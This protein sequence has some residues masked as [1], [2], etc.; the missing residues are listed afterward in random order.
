MNQGGDAL[1]PSEPA[2]QKYVQSM[3]DRI[4]PGYELV[5]RVMTFGLDARWRSRL[6][7]AVTGAG[8]DRALDIGCG[9]GD[10]VREL[11]RR[12]VGV[13]GLDLSMGML[14]IAGGAEPRVQAVGEAL[15]F[16]DS[17]FDAVT[18]GFAV[19]NFSD[20]RRVFAEVARVLKP[21]GRFGVLEVATPRNPLIRVGHQIYFSKVV[22][23][24]G[25]LLSKDHAAYRYL[26]MSVVYLPSPQE[27]GRLLVDCGFFPPTRIR[28]GM[29]AAQI[30]IAERR[31]A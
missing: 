24:I 20:P 29:G 28:V 14:A 9:T 26:P 23:V 22:P 12:G 5:N 3:F 10:L 27:W 8:V 25:G 11:S 13:T 19:R 17:T 1:L 4:A 31:A 18:S 16:S 7:D 6:V 2:K 30:V 21:G 15:P